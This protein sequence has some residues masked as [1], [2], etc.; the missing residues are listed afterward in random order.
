L[1]AAISG[2]TA[3]RALPTAVAV[4][5]HAGSGL[6]A[7]RFDGTAPSRRIG[8]VYRSSSARAEEFGGLAEAMRDAVTAA[9]LAVRLAA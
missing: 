1:I 7:R 6:E 5:A 8:L 2:G 9:R 3:T 4:D